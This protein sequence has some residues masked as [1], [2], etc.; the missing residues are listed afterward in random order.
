[1]LFLIFHFLVLSLYNLLKSHW[2][3]PNIFISFRVRFS[4][5]RILFKEP[6]NLRLSA[7]WMNEIVNAVHNMFRPHS[8]EK[9]STKHHSKLC[10]WVFCLLSWQ[11]ASLRCAWQ[12]SVKVILIQCIRCLDNTN[13]LLPL[14][15]FPSC[16]FYQRSCPAC[17]TRR[18]ASL[19]NFYLYR[20]N[21]CLTLFALFFPR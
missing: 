16:K 5:A 1:M 10:A 9:C 11:R 7:R 21:L 17:K 13:I 6:L 20:T 2:S 3:S 8:L 4:K 15:C 14:C 12:H 18:D 19:H